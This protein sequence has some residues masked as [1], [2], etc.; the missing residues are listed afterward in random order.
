MGAFRLIETRIREVGSGQIR[1]GLDSAMLV[2]LP[3]GSYTAKVS[4]FGGITGVALIE[5]YE[6]PN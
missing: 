3:P 2:T 6:M 4:G 1:S 5:I